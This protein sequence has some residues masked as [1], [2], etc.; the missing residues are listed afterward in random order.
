M[1]I[2]LE[3]I[4]TQANE[5][6]ITS[7]GA[8]HPELLE[9][10][11]NFLKLEMERL[12]IRHRFG[13]GG[14]E[15]AKARSYLVDLIIC[16]ACQA[17]ASGLSL[18]EAE[19]SNSSAVVA[20]GG[21]GRREM[22][23]FS[24]VDV[25][26]LHSGKSRSAFKPFV[27]RVL[28][29]LWDVGL[30]V[31]HSFRSVGECVSI[32]RK[33]LHSRNAMSESRQ[34]AGSDALFRRLARELDGSIFNSKRDSETYLQEILVELAARYEKFGKTI[35]MQ[36]P[37]LKESAGGLR[38]L[39]AILWAGRVRLGC[40]GLDDLRA[41]DH[42]SGPEYAA[43]RRAYDF[44]LRVRNEAHFST[45]RKTDLLTLD[46]QPLLADNLGYEP[47]RG[48]LGSE[49]FM[50]DYYN[51][52]NELH[53]ISRRFFFRLSGNKP[54]QK[55]RILLVGRSAQQ[56]ALALFPGKFETKTGP[57]DVQSEPLRLFDLFLGAQDKNVELADELKQMVRSNLRLVDR[58]LRSS[59]LAAEKFAS[60]LER[61]GRAGLALRAMHE[62]GFLG[63]FLPEFGRITFLVQHD[64]YHKYTID[65]HTIRAVEALDR[66][67]SR[68][69][70]WL[71]RFAAVSAQIEDRAALCLAL[72][73]HDIGKG[74]GGEHSKRGMRTAERICRRLGFDSQRT[75]SVMF[76]IQH[77][78]LMSRLSQRRDLNEEGLIDGFVTKVGS[79]EYLNMLLLLTYADTSAVGPGVWN[80]W[81]ATLLWELYVSAR[82]GFGGH[83]S[84]MREVNRGIDIKNRLVDDLRD[85]F[86]PSE[87][88]RHLAMMPERYVKSAR[89][90]LIARDLM[91]IRSLSETGVVT[92]WR[93]GERRITELT[94]CARD[95]AGL[96]ARIAGALTVQ[97]VNILSA[98][99]NTREDGVVL[100]VLRVA[101]QSGHQQVSRERWPDLDEALENAI[102]GRTDIAAIIER[103]LS[104][105]TR[106]KR[107]G[108]WRAIRPEVR[109]DS[110]SSAASTVVE[111][112]AE[113]APGL[114]YR[115]SNT[116]AEL[117]LTITFA[118]IATEKN[119][120]LDV[121]YVTDSQ[122]N[123]LTPNDL[124]A[125]RDR[126][127]ST[128]VSPGYSKSNKEAI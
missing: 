73:L 82:A 125:V 108:P 55:N 54:P 56:R 49:I 33:D 124:C 101:G 118:K 79:L 121:F 6:L 1:Q 96:F 18:S 9:S 127:L 23:P 80:D 112:K 71:A 52:A 3:R 65:E 28:Y 22:S 36:E 12:R 97:G 41:G 21:Y 74:R 114:A 25:M 39:H 50:R 116:L 94:I 61:R 48:L 11:K 115:I 109:F 7:V 100:D 57:L 98:D 126:L 88:E 8:D 78:L 29:L 17:A 64:F 123:K 113:D 117:G 16:R 110:E 70:P 81:K 103:W 63:R 26:F 119:C 40:N 45:G 37:N 42:L 5:K 43:A 83:A 92:D 31:G 111:V 47:K 104:K 15:I 106:P 95:S 66:V 13:L 86:L 72:L 89:S 105:T 93:A 46:L 85:R 20:L 2:D 35:C 68:D 62:S 44:I 75:A 107:R 34:V 38:D 30:T 84:R 10:F 24:D 19:L 87:V 58:G 128:L 120:A 69:D 32:A 91:L 53:Q 59:A 60:I 27:E 77:H 76:L 4:L 102:K 14:F 67:E 51:H 122:G 90:D 99:L